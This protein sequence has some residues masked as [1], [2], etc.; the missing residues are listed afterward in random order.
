MPT[1]RQIQ[2]LLHEDRKALG[3]LFGKTRLKFLSE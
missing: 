1:A 3:T 2:C